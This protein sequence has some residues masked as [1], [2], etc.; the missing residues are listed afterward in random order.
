M[1]SYSITLQFL[2]RALD[3]VAEGC[4]LN[5]SDIRFYSY[6]SPQIFLSVKAAVTNSYLILTTCEVLFYMIFGGSYAKG[7][8]C[9]GLKPFHSGS[10]A[11]VLLPGAAIFCCCRGHHYIFLRPCTL[12]AYTQDVKFWILL[13]SKTVTTHPL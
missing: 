1:F 11:L 12:L 13:F 9:I 8:M 5:G 10:G 7:L 4:S 6:Y 3:L 2:V